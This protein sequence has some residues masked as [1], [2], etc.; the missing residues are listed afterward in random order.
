MAFGSRQ[1][2]L[3]RR[4]WLIL[5]ALL[6]ASLWWQ[7]CWQLGRGDAGISDNK[8]GTLSSSVLE[9]GRISGR[10]LLDLSD[11][12]PWWKI[13]ERFSGVGSFNKRRLLLLLLW[14]SVMV[15]LALAGRGGEE[16]GQFIALRNRSEGV[17]GLSAAGFFG[18]PQRR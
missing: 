7:E 15:M 11:V 3:A 4:I 1:P 6:D 13:R 2:D 18:A 8:A 17:W 9:I 12:F 5:Y 10:L 16:R 14:L